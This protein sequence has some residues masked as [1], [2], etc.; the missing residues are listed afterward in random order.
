MNL[1]DPGFHP[2]PQIL[3]RFFAAK[4]TPGGAGGTD[5]HKRLALQIRVQDGDGHA[6]D[7]ALGHGLPAV[8]IFAQC[9]YAEIFQ[10]TPVRLFRIPKE[11]RHFVLEVVNYIE[12]PGAKSP[13]VRES[14]SSLQGRPFVT[15]FPAAP[16]PGGT[17]ISAGRSMH[18]R[19]PYAPPPD[20]TGEAAGET[21][22]P[23]GGSAAD[24]AE[25]PDSSA[26]R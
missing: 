26:G 23:P 4:N 1:D 21:P 8:F 10:Q 13:G 9:A 17:G 5:D 12:T 19:L 18:R 3:L 24:P 20:S 11:K 16:A 15:W 7:V 2:E 6:V 25:P 22:V 14:K